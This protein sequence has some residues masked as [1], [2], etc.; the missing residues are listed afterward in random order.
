MPSSGAFENV[1]RLLPSEMRA[2]MRVFSET[3]QDFIE[4]IRLRIGYP[5]S[6]LT[7]SKSVEIGGAGRVSAHSLRSVMELATGASAYSA[8]EFIRQGYLTVRGGFRIGIC[9]TAL[10]RE[11]SVFNLRDFSSLSIR[12]PSERKGC[13]DS[14]FEQVFGA[15][16]S[17]LLIISPPG[18]GKTTLLRELV[19]KLSDAGTRVSLADER[20]EVAACFEGE[21]QFDLGPCTDIMSGAPKAEA[22][23]MLLRSMNPEVIA[24]DEITAP[25]DIKASESASNCG[26]SVIATAHAGG[27]EDLCRRSLYR[28]LIER[29]IFDL[30][31]TISMSG[32]ER[33]Y[34][35]EELVF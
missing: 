29:Q 26:V 2:P 11:G 14:F 12:L 33:R 13:A 20:S 10:M 25:E 30:A 28:G 3:E 24:L 17:S 35:V 6:I 15:G 23:I 4:E 19:R 18:L 31:V 5:P 34:R 9:G 32:G 1:L 21:P 16:L 8:S 27:I 7:R 22:A